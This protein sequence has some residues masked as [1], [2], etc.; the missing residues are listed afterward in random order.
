MKLK[1]GVMPEPVALAIVGPYLQILYDCY[2][3][4]WT[5]CGDAPSRFP[6]FK[7]GKMSCASL[8]YDAVTSA[9]KMAFAEFVE[10]GAVMMT[11]APRFLLIVFKESMGYAGKLGIKFNKVD[12]DERPHRSGTDQGAMIYGQQLFWPEA[13]AA[14]D[15]L[16]QVGTMAVAGYCPDPGVRDLPKFSLA[17][18]KNGERVWSIPIEGTDA[19]SVAEI[20]T[21][22][23][24]GGGKRVRAK[25]AQPRGE[26]ESG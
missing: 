20:V 10:S 14:G 16:G 26:V 25:D 15:L 18:H 11:E 1:F 24:T 17:C 9:V 3:K 19:G 5:W 7:V 4:A 12:E 13:A 2:R 21:G 8:M 6:D 23:T 22:P